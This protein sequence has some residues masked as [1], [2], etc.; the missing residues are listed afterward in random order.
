MNPP[1]CCLQG[2]LFRC[3]DRHR[4]KVKGKK[5]IFHAN[6]NQKKAEVAI[7]ISDKIDFK[8]KTVIRD[9]DGHY[10]TIKDPFQQ[11]MK[12]ITHHEQVGCIPRTQGWLNIC[13]SVN[14]IYHI[15]K[16]KHKNH[17][18]ISIDADKAF[19]KI[20]HPF[21]IHSQQSGYRRNLSEHNKDHI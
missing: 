4:L 14:V 6:G 19:D 12:R 11:Y 3:K 15:N 16:M 17:M 7:S 13:K 18:I 9:K 2:T 8:T 1:I 21:M 20:Q 5:K 10:I